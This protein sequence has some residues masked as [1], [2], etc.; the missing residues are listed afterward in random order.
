MIVALITL[1]AKQLDINYQIIITL[2]L[3]KFILITFVVIWI[4]IFRLTFLE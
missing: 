1:Y 3:T 2:L 4:N